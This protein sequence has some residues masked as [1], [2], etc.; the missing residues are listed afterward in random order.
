MSQGAV[1][2][3]FNNPAPA[4]AVVP[5]VVAAAVGL[6]LL[7]ADSA[8]WLGAVLLPIGVALLIL[9]AVAKGVAW[10]IALERQHRSE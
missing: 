8:A 5:G 1:P 6:H 3:Q 2:H 9:G 4:V 7:V 10:G